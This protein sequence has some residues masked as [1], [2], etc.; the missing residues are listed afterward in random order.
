MKY[1][2]NLYA[3]SFF[4]DNGIS[5]QILMYQCLT[6]VAMFLLTIIVTII[7]PIDFGILFTRISGILNSLVI[8]V[9][10]PLFY[11]NGDF[12]F[13]NKV[14]NHGLYA[15]LKKELFQINAEFQREVIPISKMVTPIPV[16]PIEN[17][18]EELFEMET[19]DSQ[20]S[21][22]RKQRVDPTQIIPP[23]EREEVLP[24]KFCEPQKKDILEI[25]PVP[26]SRCRII[27]VKPYD[28][29]QD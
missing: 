5:I 11:L 14:M 22:Q 24:S 10:Q 9:I 28:A 29:T 6:E 19:H 23:N 27:H 17:D 12:N 15:A 7:I 4:S 16:F 3:K 18:N 1:F 20:I 2:E 26:I 13:R 21:R 8:F 25:K